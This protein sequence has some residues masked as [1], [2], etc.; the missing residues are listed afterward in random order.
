VL[1]WCDTSNAQDFVGDRVHLGW[2]YRR[3]GLAPAMIGQFTTNII[4]HVL[5]PLVV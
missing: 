3:L 5:L 1:F 4:L 2:R